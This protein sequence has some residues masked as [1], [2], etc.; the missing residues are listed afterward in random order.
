VFLEEMPTGQSNQN[1]Q[2]EV[3]N[4]YRCHRQYSA[5]QDLAQFLAAEP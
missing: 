5:A 4:V 2:Q 3:N 1:R